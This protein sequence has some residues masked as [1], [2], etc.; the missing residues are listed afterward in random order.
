MMSLTICL[1]LL[2]E[3]VGLVVQSLVDLLYD[4]CARGVDVRRGLDG[5][6]GSDSVWR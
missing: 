6:D 1:W 2:V 3:K 4:T 5:L